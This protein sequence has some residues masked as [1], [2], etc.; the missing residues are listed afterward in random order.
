MLDQLAHLLERRVEIRHRLTSALIYPALL[1]V[2]ALISIF[3]IVTVLVPNI[4]P[5]FE[6]SEAQLPAVVKV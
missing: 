3:V 1:V 2:M 4:R 6:G 5:L